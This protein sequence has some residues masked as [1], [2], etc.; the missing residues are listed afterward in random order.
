MSTLRGVSLIQR[1]TERS[2]LVEFSPRVDTFFDVVDRETQKLKCHWSPGPPSFSTQA[3]GRSTRT[4]LRRWR[5]S[6]TALERGRER[7]SVC[8]RESL[9]G[10]RVA[11]KKREA[12]P[13][14]YRPGASLRAWRKLRATQGCD[15]LDVRGSVSSSQFPLSF[16]ADM[17]G[18]VIISLQGLERWTRCFF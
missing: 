14:D 10:P 6:P 7:E 17:L 8:E 2:S 15:S 16:M 1:G 13:G 18:R 5:A 9:P 11:R 4:P 3:S 12:P